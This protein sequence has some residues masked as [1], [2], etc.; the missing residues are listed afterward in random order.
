MTFYYHMYGSSINTLNIYSN[1]KVVFQERD[2]LGDV[3]TKGS[4]TLNGNRNVRTKY[5][6]Y[7]KL[8]IRVSRTENEL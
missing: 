4:V 5:F 6:E 3:W 2:P 8:I 7:M 1:G